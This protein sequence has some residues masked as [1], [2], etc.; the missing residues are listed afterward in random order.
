MMQK[1]ETST[2]AAASWSRPSATKSARPILLKGKSALSWP[3]RVA[4]KVSRC[5]AGGKVLPRAC[6]TAC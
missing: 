3:V 6:V 2:D 1:P 5:C 4:R